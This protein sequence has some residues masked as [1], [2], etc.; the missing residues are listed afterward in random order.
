MNERPIHSSNLGT[1]FQQFY[2]ILK[3]SEFKMVIKFFRRFE[4][5][6]FFNFINFK[7]FSTFA[8]FKNFMQNGKPL[9]KGGREDNKFAK[10]KTLLKFIQGLT[11][12]NNH[13]ISKKI[14]CN[15][16]QRRN[17]LMKQAYFNFLRFLFNFPLDLVLCYFLTFFFPFLT[18]LKSRLIYD[19]LDKLA[20]FV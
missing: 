12:S 3:V 18:Q 20:A 19:W 2:Q 14:I 9:R 16:S 8:Q 11:S 7:N 1:H 5:F 4:N 13:F 17:Y 10:W 15:D 6:N